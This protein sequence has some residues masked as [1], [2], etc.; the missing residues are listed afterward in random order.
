[1]LDGKQK[2][3]E[4]ERHRTN[5]IPSE[6]IQCNPSQPNP[7]QIRIQNQLPAQCHAI[8]VLYLKFQPQHSPPNSTVA[9]QLPIQMATLLAFAY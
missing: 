6:P 7:I 5:L 9:A 1:M 4:T 8:S 2:R 3:W